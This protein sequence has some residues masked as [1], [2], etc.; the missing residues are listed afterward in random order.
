MA[1]GGGPVFTAIIRDITERKLADEALR[2]SQIQ[3]IQQQRDLAA[4]E[5]RSKCRAICT[6]VL[7]RSLGMSTCILRPRRNS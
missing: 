7:G 5:E 3:I 1:G 4:A 6:I 2:Q